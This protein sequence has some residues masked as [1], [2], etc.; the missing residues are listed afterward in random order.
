M[1]ISWWYIVL[2]FYK[3]VATGKTEKSIQG[4]FMCY[5]LQLH[6]NL[7]SQSQTDKLGK[8]EYPHVSPFYLHLGNTGGF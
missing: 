4:I 3:N 7:S 2:Y 5:F 1:P 8:S 6:I